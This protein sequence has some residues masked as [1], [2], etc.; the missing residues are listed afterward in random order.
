MKLTSGVDVF[1]TLFEFVLQSA[2]Y[3]SYDRLDSVYI[4]I[5]RIEMCEIV[6][7]PVQIGGVCDTSSI[8]GVCI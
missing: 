5:V 8:S 2:S 6:R 1:L 4:I 3:F 7:Y